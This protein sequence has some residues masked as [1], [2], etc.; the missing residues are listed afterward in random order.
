MTTAL[1]NLL[2][3]Q[4][5]APTCSTTDSSSCLAP[6]EIRTILLTSDSG[7]FS[8]ELIISSQEQQQQRQASQGGYDYTTAHQIY[9]E[10][11]LHLL[12][13]YL[14]HDTSHDNNWQSTFD[15]HSE[16]KK[17]QREGSPDSEHEGQGQGQGEGEREKQ[18]GFQTF[19]LRR[20]VGINKFTS[21]IDELNPRLLYPLGAKVVSRSFSHGGLSLNGFFHYLLDH[22]M[23]SL[24]SM[25]EP[26]SPSAASRY[27]ER[28]T[29]LPSQVQQEYVILGSDKA[30]SYL[31]KFLRLVSL[32][33]SLS[34]SLSL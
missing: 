32:I 30:L 8:I 22:E 29:L 10:D 12:V 7:L 28:T 13:S 6:E 33:L 31:N 25:T 4:G 21:K 3:A 15:I 11:F 24:S 26:V 2:T 19:S 1:D 27:Y 9:L 14:A 5:S 16:M 23:L 17:E 18:D 34:I 20:A